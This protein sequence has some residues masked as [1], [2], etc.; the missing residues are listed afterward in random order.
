ML[1]FLFFFN[2]CVCMHTC[3]CV[4][5]CACVCMHM[6]WQ[7]PEEAKRGH[8]IPGAGAAGGCEPPVSAV[9]QLSWAVGWF[10]SSVLCSVLFS[11][12]VF[13]LHFLGYFLSFFSVMLG[14]NPGSHENW[15]THWHW[16]SLS[17][18]TSSSLYSNRFV[19]VS[20]WGLILSKY[21]VLIIHAQYLLVP[22]SWG[23]VLN[24]SCFLHYHCFTQYLFFTRLFTWET[25][26]QWLIIFAWPFLI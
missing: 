15:E 11:S 5:L 20:S 23:S 14:I 24:V 9:L 1:L 3:V 25:F 10:C 6:C 12:S 4:F 16:T 8:E 22:L 13:L 21:E 19:G 26:L 18:P 7:V 2:L 17:A